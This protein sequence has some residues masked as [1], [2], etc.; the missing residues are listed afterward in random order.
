MG[1]GTWTLTNTNT[2]SGNTLVTQGTLQ[3]NSNLAIENSAF[4]TT[5]PGA[6]PLR[7]AS[8]SPPSAG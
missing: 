1:S 3:L 4:D 5:S 7:P 6:S 2:Y 8:P